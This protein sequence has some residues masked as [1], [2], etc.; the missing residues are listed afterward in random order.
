MKKNIILKRFANLLIIIILLGCSRDDSYNNTDPPE[1]ELINPLQEFSLTISEPSA[2]AYNSVNNS[3]MIVSDGSP[4]I[5]EVGFNGSVISSFTTTCSDL[6]GITLS[7]NCDTIYVT[8]EKK[9]LV[10]ALNLSGNTLYSFLV[11]VAISDNSALEGISINKNNNHLFVINEK[12]PIMLLEFLGTTEISR[13]LIDKV[14]DISDVFYEESSNSIWIIS[15]E[16]Q[17]IL[18][19]SSSGVFIK[20]WKIPFTKGEGLTIVGNKMY[21]VNDS[22]AKLYVFN[23]AS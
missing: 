18:K 6:E 2:V 11:D 1:I 7:K 20:E 3:L 19:Y 9:K 4:I 16:S 13:I 10:T 21:I 14:S 23:K 12:D 15:D 17:K 8:Q 5:Y 22:N